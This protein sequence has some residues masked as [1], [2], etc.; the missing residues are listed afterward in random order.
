MGYAKSSAGM[1]ALLD[2]T[3]EEINMLM[4][5]DI[6]N[7]WGGTKD[8]AINASNKGSIIDFLRKNQNINV[9]L[10]PV[11]HK[12]DLNDHMQVNE[13]GKTQYRKLRKITKNFHNV[14]LMSVLSERNIYCA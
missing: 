2:R 7:F 8:V 12:F 6:V 4:K 9:I 14:S 3:K 5:K 11:P 13:E 10:I 1:S